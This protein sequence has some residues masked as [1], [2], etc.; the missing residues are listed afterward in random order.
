MSERII[1]I[2]ADSLA[3]ARR[4]LY[5]DDLIVLEESILHQEKVETIEAIADTV[6]EAVAI[7]NPRIPAEAEI[8]TQEVI[9]T[10]Q[11]VVLQIKEYD[12]ESIGKEI[13]QKKVEVIESIS[14]HKKGRK[15]FLGFFKT[16]NIYEVT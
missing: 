6:E 2:E 9:V 15:G 11:R 3:E 14:L 13:K 4:A 1:V 10:P 7:L 5:H 12:K 8:E 16:P